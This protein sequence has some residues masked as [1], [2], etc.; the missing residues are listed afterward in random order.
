MANTN[1]GFTR[2][3]KDCSPQI[4][5]RT[6]QNGF[7]YQK[8]KSGTAYAGLGLYGYWLGCLPS[9]G[10]EYLQGKL[11]DTLKSNKKYCISLY[12]SLADSSYY[13]TDDIGLYFSNIKVSDTSLTSTFC[14]NFPYIP[15][16]IN[17]K[18][19]FIT[20]TINWTLIKGLY[21]A[22]GGERYLTIGNFAGDTLDLIKTGCIP[23]K[24]QIGAYYYL[25]DVS[26][27]QITEAEA[28]Q[29][30]TICKG[31]TAS[32]GEQSKTG[33][34]Y[35]WTPVAG[36]NN[37]SIAKPIASPS[38]T[39][40][41]YLIITDTNSICRCTSR[42]SVVVSVIGNQYS[43]SSEKNNLC[44]GESITL[45]ASGG[46]SYAWSG[47]QSGEIITVLPT[48]NTTYTVTV[49]DSL[50]CSGTANTKINII[51]CD[52][53]TNIDIPNV[54]TPNADNNNDEFKIK[55]KGEFENFSV[56]IFNRWG[57]KL[58]ESQNINFTWD[59][60]TNTGYIIPDGT[61]YYIISAKGKDGKNWNLHGNITV[62]R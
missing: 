46:I 13:A 11:S 19:N 50:G 60:R 45:T 16:I 32:I 40:T 7:G 5:Y 42:D 53:I 6:P 35:Y 47:G 21:I 44:I 4:N 14:V 38:I 57:V 39:T 56:E 54:L 48:I 52:T 31:D 36:L 28:G 33:I 58:F 18:G 1:Y 30:K 9:Y 37:P 23:Q 55:Y 24:V 62:I 12:V 25:D 10:R 34:I 61:Y 29:N 49:T 20:D 15:Q 8:P 17:P 26:V 2:C 43:V 3:F 27:V 51:N 59:A 41:Y 22:Q